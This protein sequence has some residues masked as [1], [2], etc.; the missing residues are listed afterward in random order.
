MT[1]LAGPVRSIMVVP[2]RTRQEATAFF[3][4][5]DETQSAAQAAVLS[6]SDTFTA[7]RV[8]PLTHPR[9]RVSIVTSG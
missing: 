3:P 2:P 7:A 5:V 4:Q 8:T 6:T 1:G 9:V